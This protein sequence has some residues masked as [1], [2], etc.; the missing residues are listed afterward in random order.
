MS[1]R[2]LELLEVLRRLG[3]SAR[4]SELAKTL[5]VSEETVR[6]I[7]K[8]LA[9][10]GLVQRVHGGAYLSGP[11]ATEGFFRR[12][13]EHT[14][15][16]QKIASAIVSEVSDGMTVFMDVGSTTAFAAQ[17]LRKKANLT[18]VTNSIGVAQTLA[19][20]NGNSV[21]LL[22]GEIQSNERGTFGASAQNQ[23]SGFALDL[24][25]LSVD[26]F[27]AKQGP[28]Y[29]SALEAQLA[30]TAADAAERTAVILA[31][32]KFEERAPYRGPQPENLD[33]IVTDAFPSKKHRRSLETWGIQLIVQDEKPNTSEDDPA[34]SLGE[35]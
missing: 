4:S 31:H 18:I 32:P 8:T 6:R 17:G 34:S 2:E 29:R 24:A 21:H 12:I 10:S 1:H 22:G 14:D 30:I 9:K 23:L 25:V 33:L 11:D 15:E 13:A 7:I 27:T 26:G 28:L 16:K 3:G 35:K 5:D 20:H 19:H